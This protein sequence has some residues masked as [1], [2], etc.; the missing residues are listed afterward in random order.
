MRYAE[1]NAAVNALCEFHDLLRLRIAL[2]GDD[3]WFFIPEYEPFN[4]RIVE[5]SSSADVDSTVDRLRH[6]YMES[7]GGYCLF[8]YLRVCD[9]SP[10][11]LLVILDHALFDQYAI[12]ILTEDL[13]TAF[14]QVAFGQTIDLGQQTMPYR[15]WAIAMNRYLATSEAQA[16]V[17]YWLKRCSKPIF[18]IPVDRPQG[19]PDWRIRSTKTKVVLSEETTTALL[20]ARRRHG[21][22]MPELLTTALLFVL[23]EMYALNNSALGLTIFVNQR[24]DILPCDVSR[25]VGGFS[26]TCT[27]I[28]DIDH[29]S[30]IEQMLASVRRQA[31]ETPH[32]GKLQA[33]LGRLTIEL[34][35]IP[36][37]GI[38]LNYRGHSQV[39]THAGAFQDLSSH[40]VQ[41]IYD[42]D[43]IYFKDALSEGTIRWPEFVFPVLPL[44]Q[45]M[46]LRMHFIELHDFEPGGRLFDIYINDHCVCKELDIV[47]EVGRDRP[48][49]VDF[50]CMVNQH[51]SLKVNLVSY[52]T[53]KGKAT[54]SAIEILDPDPLNKGNGNRPA[55]VH[56]IHAGGRHIPGL[57]TP[58]ELLHTSSFTSDHMPDLSGCENAL[59]ADVYQSELYCSFRSPEEWWPTLGL[60]CD[61]IQKRLCCTLASQDIIHRPAT[62]ERMMNLLLNNLNGLAGLL[63]RSADV[64]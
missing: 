27:V 34:Q 45:P 2:G 16:D 29:V 17:E 43:G 22:T 24:T 49:I 7:L 3:Q 26:S 5:V 55:R 31:A 51:G 59:P 47:R 23:Q 11:R 21:V 18:R 38:F 33:W 39:N 44:G 32:G 48:L 1:C 54:I 63:S 58:E 30:S 36:F 6:E 35:D 60:D 10:D 12:E 20:R 15:D 28:F 40:L 19:Y 37:S 13:T 62:V 46:I 25:T 41:E 57:D 50:K 4:I 52:S 14:Q 42:H 9:A 53:T 61:L 64:A 56:G 8:A